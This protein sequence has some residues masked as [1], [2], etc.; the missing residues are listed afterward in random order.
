MGSVNR[1][2]PQSSGRQKRITVEWAAFECQS[3]LALA[4]YGKTM[5]NGAT[6]CGKTALIGGGR[7]GQALID[8][9]IQAGRLSGTELHVID[10]SEAAQAWWSEHHPQSRVDNELVPAVSSAE[11]VILA[12]KPDLVAPVAAQAAGHWGGRLVMSVAA[13]ITLAKLVDWLATDRVI[14]VMPN[15][16]CLVGAGAS[17]YCCG[18]GASDADKQRVH[19]VLS[20][21]GLVVEVAE[22]QMDAVTGLSGSGPAYVCVIIEALADGGVL[23]GLPRDVAMRLATQTVLGTAQMVAQSGKHPAE[24][25]DAVAS[26]GGTTIAGL[27]AMEQNGVRAGLI[28][29]VSA[30]AI[31][32]SELG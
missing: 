21:V 28:N 17:A 3:S 30:A 24:L 15:T 1:I 2:P 6:L 25:K 5:K 9:L 8:G 19:T 27:R 32:S 29:A 22:K 7:M 20:S 16:P 14:R 31:R 26:P 23:A 10:P 13:G 4:R 12:V 11:T 18:G